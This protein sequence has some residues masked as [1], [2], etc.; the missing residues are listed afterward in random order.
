MGYTLDYFCADLTCPRCGAVTRSEDVEIQTKIRA[1][2]Q[3]ADLRVGDRV[4]PLDPLG[5]LVMNPPDGDRVRLVEE[6]A[7]KAGCGFYPNWVEITIEHDTITR[8]A[9]TELD[10]TT[11]ARVNYI[12]PEARSTL[13]EVEGKSYTEIRGRPRWPAPSS[14]S[15]RE[16]ARV[17]GLADEDAAALLAVDES[18]LSS[19]ER[20][21]LDDLRRELAAGH[22]LDRVRIERVHLIAAHLP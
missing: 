15:S 18:K 20:V 21:F 19:E 3:L 9:P 14:P 17:T 2:P 12:T 6:W 7:C 22:T 8:I 13:A 16:L 1:D 5:Y 10:R 4:G 11:R